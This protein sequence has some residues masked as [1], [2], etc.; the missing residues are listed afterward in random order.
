[1]WEIREHLRSCRLG[2][3]PPSASHSSVCQCRS[4][5][6][7]HNQRPHV[8][9]HADTLRHTHKHTHTHSWIYNIN[10]QDRG[11]LKKLGFECRVFPKWL[12]IN[13]TFTLEEERRESVWYHVSVIMK[14]LQWDSIIVYPDKVRQNTRLLSWGCK[15][16]DFNIF[17]K[18]WASN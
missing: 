9:V 16:F 15:V 11:G 2:P 12:V 4:C 8:C 18:Q 17:T 5:F 7:F 10:I 3:S 6:S 13:P 1:M 14:R